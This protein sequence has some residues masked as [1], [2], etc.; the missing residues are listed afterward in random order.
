MIKLIWLFI[1]LITLVL[2]FFILTGIMRGYLRSRQKQPRIVRSYFTE[3]HVRYAA[4]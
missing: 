4:M 1:I 2:I 3:K